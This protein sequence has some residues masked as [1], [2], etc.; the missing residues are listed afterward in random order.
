MIVASKLRAYSKLVAFSH[1]I[2]AMP[3]AA[4]AVVLSLRAPHTPLTWQRL[5][6]ML[7]CMV[8]ARTAAMAFNRVVDRDVDA[9]NPRTQAREIPAGTVTLGEGV[10]LVAIASVIFVGAATTLGF[11]PTALALPVLLVLLGYSLAKRFTW[12]AHAWLGVALSLA[13]GGTWLAMGC[14]PNRGILAL[15][16]GVLTWLLG[17]DILYALQDE[18]FD[19]GFG[20][21]SIPAR[22]GMKNSIVI[23]AASHFVTVAAFGAAGGFLGRGPAF[24]CGVAMCGAI[25]AYEHWLVG[26]GRLDRINKA[27][28]DMNAYVS[29]AFFGCTVLDHWL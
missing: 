23:S 25:L 11:W 24:F 17:F 2:F 6:A 12:A 5:V 13:P 10:A 15:M 20:L 16:L 28:F 27:F 3:F 7:V 14:L 29:A 19:R 18:Q 26:W 4:S 1:T 8:S 22:F 21:H 9:K